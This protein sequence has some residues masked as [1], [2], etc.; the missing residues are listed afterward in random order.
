VPFHLRR[1]ISASL[2]ELHDLNSNDP[3]FKKVGGIFLN[4]ISKRCEFKVEV[5]KI[6]QV[7]STR[8]EIYENTKAI[9]ER[10]GISKTDLVDQ[11]GFHI[12]PSES[13][14]MKIA[15]TNLRTKTNC[16]CN[17]GRPC[18]NPG[19]MGDHRKGIYIS[20]QADD[21]FPYQTDENEY[22]QDGDC[23]FILMLKF[24]TGKKFWIRNQEAGIQPM[25][26]Y[27][28]HESKT[29]EYYI[30]DSNQV[31]PQN[32]I[33]YKLRK[34]ETVP[35]G[36]VYVLH[37]GNFVPMEEF[38]QIEMEQKKIAEE[39]RRE[40][41]QQKEKK[42]AEDKKEE[43]RIKEIEAKRAKMEKGTHHPENQFTTTNHAHRL[44]W[45]T[46]LMN[47]TCDSCNAR[48]PDFYRCAPC[49]YDYCLNCVEK[50][51]DSIKKK[52]NVTENVTESKSYFQT[53][54]ITRPKFQKTLNAST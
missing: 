29:A 11:F 22:P 30:F 54:F 41:A 34:M 18:D 53:I 16:G 38:K 32:I 14:T 43:I 24:F 51:K 8:T 7:H 26:G 10:K 4:Q 37:E 25:K 23:G 5:T 19:L 39:K 27:Q 31:L 21:C 44:T 40:E 33:Y 50:E 49:E 45:V 28:C 9:L 12:N 47:H 3:E 48:G 20:L 6:T 42:E 52:E 1:S 17:Y 36:N 2:S 35:Y 13:T 46:G 15:K